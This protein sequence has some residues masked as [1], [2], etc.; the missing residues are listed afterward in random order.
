MNDDR[1]RF[2]AKGRV[3]LG[4]LLALAATDLCT[5]GRPVRAQE[6]IAQAEEGSWKK[7]GRETGEAAESVGKATKETAGKTWKSTKDTSGNAWDTTKK[8]S[9]KAW[10][11]TKKAVTDA[12]EAVKEGAGKAVDAVKGE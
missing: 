7:A 8:T 2:F 11:A 3:V 1:K 4:I 10:K 9:K 5:E 6:M 12:V